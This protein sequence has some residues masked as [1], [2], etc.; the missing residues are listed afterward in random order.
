MSDVDRFRFTIIGAG[1]VGLAIARRISADF[2]E[3]SD[4]LVIEKEES[5][6]KGISSRNS[7][8]I[9]SGIYY[10]AGSLKHRLCVQGRRMLYDYCE[11]K[12]VPLK[13]CGKLIVATEEEELPALEKLYAQVARNNIENVLRLD[14]KDSIELEP[15]IRV[16]SALFSKETGILDTHSFMKSLE[17][18]ISDNNGTIVYG[19]SVVS[20]GHNA[21]LYSLTLADGTRFTSECVIN[22]T[23][24]Y[25]T[26]VSELLGME[27]VKL[28]PCKGTYFSYVGLHR[29]RHLIYPVPHA[30]LTGL[31]MHATID[32]GGRLKLG[33]DVEYIDSIDDYAVDKE[34]KDDF[35]KAAKRIFKTLDYENLS[36]DMA[37]IRPKIQGPHDEEIKDFYIE[38]ESEKGFPKFINLLGI[39]SP[40]LTSALA[41][42]QYVS[43]LA[44]NS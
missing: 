19:S 31:G 41:I 4:V 37:G 23:G 11:Q 8:V 1:V 30:S 27:P 20:I 9:H 5:F 28:Y 35:C 6:G 44:T 40:G 32:L 2:K 22:S 14:R 12:G 21:G 24:L 16:V 29:C 36:P 33:P 43:D 13:K 17:G 39:E 3:D 34:K 38:E 15:D 26:A 10:P 42:G 25:A 18:E 7:E